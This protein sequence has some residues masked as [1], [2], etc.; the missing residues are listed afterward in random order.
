MPER[1]KVVLIE[2]IAW[3][4]IL[5][6]ALVLYAGVAAMALTEWRRKRDNLSQLDGTRWL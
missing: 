2:V 4:L 1:L 6:L 5:P 3:P